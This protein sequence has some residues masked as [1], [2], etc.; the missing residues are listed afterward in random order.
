MDFAIFT[1]CALAIALAG[2]VLVRAVEGVGER[3]GLGHLWL[4]TVLLAG[5]TSLPELVSIV[6]AAGIDQPDIAVGT[7]LGSNMFNMTIFGVVLVL[8]P[9]AVRTDRA[10]A[11]TGGVAIVLGAA[12][13]VFLLSGGGALGHVGGGAIV[14][15]ALYVGGSLLLFRED[16]RAAAAAANPDVEPALASMPRRG[17]VLQLLAATAVVFVASLFLPSAAEG[18][19]E[20]LGVSGGVVGVVGVALATSLPE[21]VTSAVALWRGA[22][23]LVVGNVFGSNVFNVAVLFPGDLAL[24]EGPLLAAAM[25]EQAVT[26]AFG[27]L[28]MLLALAALVDRMPWSSQGGRGLRRRSRALRLLGGGILAGYVVGVVLTVGLGIETG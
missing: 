7:V 23:G 16:R 14:L 12:T 20:T 11:L 5:A 9:L 8:F 2:P 18:I 17:D 15:L 4:G 19:A 24:D 3:T 27:L 26:A 21:V 1:V 25:D 6:A 28:L 10:G 22:P 13:L